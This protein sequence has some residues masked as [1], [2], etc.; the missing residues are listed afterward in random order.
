[1]NEKTKPSITE[2]EHFDSNNDSNTY[3]GSSTYDQ[4]EISE[5][6][7][8]P[9]AGLS[10]EQVEE[11]AERF[12]KD[13]GLAH[14]SE[15]FRKAA[16]VAQDSSGTLQLL[17][18]SAVSSNFS[19]AFAPRAG[20][21]SLSQLT[22][23]DKEVFRHEI[24]HKWD[25]PKMLYFL[26]GLCSL[27]AAVQG[28]RISGIFL[29]LENVAHINPSFRWT[30]ASQTLHN[31]SSLHNSASIP[32]TLTRTQLGINGASHLRCLSPSQA[33]GKLI[34]FQNRIL[35]IVIS[36]PY[37]CC[38]VLGCWLTDPLNYYFGRRGTIFIT[39]LLSGL[40]CIWQGVTN[41]WPHLFVRWQTLLFTRRPSFLPL[42]LLLRSPVLFL[43]L[44]SAPNP[45]EFMTWRD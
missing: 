30:K 22:E 14:L 37:L 13:N 15:T 3:H 18:L 36:A 33:G 43:V 31:S 41:S 32:P 8:N 4:A 44:E 21:E 29:I 28:V 38:G 20:F 24:T 1:M 35:G 11:D 40:T 25:Q 42:P 2:Q 27:A 10:H 16:L 45:R 34:I 9:L 17:S 12:A 26:V 23:E 5:K 6:L 7:A 19:N 39:A